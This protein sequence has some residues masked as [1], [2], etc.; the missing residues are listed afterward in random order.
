MI[1]ENIEKYV[2][3]KIDAIKK[4]TE[5]KVFELEFKNKKNAE[6]IAEQE[7]TIAR[8]VFLNNQLTEKYRALHH[9]IDGYKD[10][11]VMEDFRQSLAVMER[12]F[13]GLTHEKRIQ[14]TN[15]EQVVFLMQDINTVH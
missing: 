12:C 10:P 13:E 1:E 14:Y 9:L 8:H 7:N 3:Q 6:R 2:K 5:K 15:M 11:A 4:A